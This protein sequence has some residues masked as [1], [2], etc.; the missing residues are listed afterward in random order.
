MAINLGTAAG[1]APR[2]EMAWSLPHFEAAWWYESQYANEQVACNR[3]R[4]IQGIMSA[5]RGSAAVYEVQY[6][7]G[8]KV[9][10]ERVVA[11][12]GNDRPPPRGNIRPSSP[13]LR[14]AFAQLTGDWSA[15]QPKRKAGRAYRTAASLMAMA[16][17]SAMMF[18]AAFFAAKYS[19]QVP[20]RGETTAT[21]G[22]DRKVHGQVLVPRVGSQICDRF[23][24]DNNSGLMKT[25][26]SQPCDQ[27]NSP[28]NLAEQANSF[29][30]GWR[31]GK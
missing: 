26:E 9:L 18:G 6:G 8:G 29:A 16:C 1:S 14:A 17:L 30:A 7:D 15:R 25:L 19:W 28:A 21:T 2:Y 22:A 31:G 11:Q 27:K 20:A 13:Q 3:L 12:C 5:Q 10:S 24:F 4:E 23:L